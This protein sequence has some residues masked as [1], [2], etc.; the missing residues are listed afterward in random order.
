MWT[1]RWGP[2]K[3]TVATVI[4]VVA[5]IATI[6]GFVLQWVTPLKPVDRFVGTMAWAWQWLL[7]ILTFGVPVW[8][9]LILAAVIVGFVALGSRGAPGLPLSPELRAELQKPGWV[10]YTKDRILGL[11]CEWTWVKAGDR[12]SVD[13]RAILCPKC[14][15]ELRWSR[16]LR[17]RGTSLDVSCENCGF[18]QVTDV[19]DEDPKDRIARVVH[20]RIRSGEWKRA[21]ARENGAETTA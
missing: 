9:L 10:T 8:V 6:T 5:G 2:V 17:V 3:K 4:G 14:R 15:Y 13:V 19:V 11:D 1:V 16:L 21:V 7:A 20:Q 18:H 12:F